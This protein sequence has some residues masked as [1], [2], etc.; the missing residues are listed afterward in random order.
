MATRGTIPQSA[1]ADSPLYTR[2]PLRDGAEEPVGTG[3]ARPSEPN[4]AE[5]EAKA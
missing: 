3:I 2:G 5:P 1:N 4:A